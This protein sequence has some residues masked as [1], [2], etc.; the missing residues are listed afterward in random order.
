MK[1]TPQQIIPFGKRKNPVEDN[2][3]GLLAAAIK[4]TTF[5]KG[6]VFFTE[7]KHCLP[8]LY[9]IREG[10]VSIHTSKNLNLA[11][12][13]GFNVS[14]ADA[15]IIEKNG[16]FGNDTMGDNE[17]GEF[18]IAQYTVT[19]LEDVVV[20]VLDM[21][22][23]KKVI[24]AKSEVKVTM[25]DL[26]MVRI[27]GA[28]TFGKVWLVSNKKTKD[29]YALKVQNK[30]DIIDYN[31]V[32]GVIREKDIMA[33][34]DHPFLIKMISHWKDENKLYML[35]K[36]YQGGELQTVIHTDS[37]DGTSTQLPFLLFAMSLIILTL[38]RTNVGVPEWAAKFYAANILEGLSYMHHR[39]IVYRDLKP[40]NVMLDSAGYTVIVDF[41]FAKIITDNKTY[42]FCGTPLYLAPEIILQKGHNAGADHWVSFQPRDINIL[43]ALP[44]YL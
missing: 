31:Q 27:L 40:A 34:V 24:A 41:G 9:L 25:D 33:K 10:S 35:M 42:T 19:A 14:K 17:S 37:R 30:K 15:K 43:L 28:G 39:S 32:D 21:I 20:G 44:C 3:L 1:R 8:A 7:G 36:M 22:A 29:S 38:N 6:H 16:Y 4:D 23:I 11:W 2:E 26:T 5:K 18:G 12:L 13:L